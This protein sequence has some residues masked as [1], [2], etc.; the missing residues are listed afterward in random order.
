MLE[1]FEV[2][3]VVG[4]FICGGI[5]SCGGIHEWACFVWAC[6][7]WAS[8]LDRTNVGRFSTNDTEPGDTEPNDT[9]HHGSCH[10]AASSG[11]VHDPPW[12]RP[13]GRPRRDAG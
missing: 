6:F 10:H 3:R 7:V 12:N 13:D 2:G 1:Q 5:D 4:Q 9:G 8:N 11:D